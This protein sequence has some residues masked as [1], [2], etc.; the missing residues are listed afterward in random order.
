MNRDTNLEKPRVT[1][2]RRV[3]VRGLIESTDA[4]YGFVTQGR[5]TVQG[6]PAGNIAD[7]KSFEGWR[8]LP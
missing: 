7:N 1:Q 6:S 3:K 2:S 4:S 5:L 8:K